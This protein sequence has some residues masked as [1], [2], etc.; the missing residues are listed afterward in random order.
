MSRYKYTRAD[1]EIAPDFDDVEAGLAP[2][3]Y[4]ACRLNPPFGNDCTHLLVRE[5]G[6]L[7]WCNQYGEDTLGAVFSAE[8]LCEE[9]S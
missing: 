4:P 6:S 2:G 7:G 9:E 8:E 3:V 1:W 5:N